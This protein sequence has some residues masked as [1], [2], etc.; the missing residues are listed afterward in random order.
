MIHWFLVK[1]NQNIFIQPFIALYKL[2]CH[3]EIAYLIWREQDLFYNYTGSINIKV[4][5]V[6]KLWE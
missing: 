1:K 4:P 3:I 2:G 6:R 5:V